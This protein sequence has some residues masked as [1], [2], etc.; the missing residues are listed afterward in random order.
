MKSKK[1]KSDLDLKRQIGICFNDSKLKEIDYLQ[2]K[3]GFKNRTEV[4]EACIGWAVKDDVIKK[5][6]KALLL[7]Y[8]VKL[9]ESLRSEAEEVN[10]SIIGLIKKED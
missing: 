8:L 10:A 9:E 6:P 3:C 7:R 1:R 4:I 2:A 5:E